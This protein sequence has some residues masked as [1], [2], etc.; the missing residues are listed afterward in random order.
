MYYPDPCDAVDCPECDGTGRL[1]SGAE[2]PTCDGGGE[3]SS[4]DAKRYWINV[5]E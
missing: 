1:D 4:G 2:C 5:D 3:V